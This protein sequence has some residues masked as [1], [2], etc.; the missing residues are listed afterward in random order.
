VIYLG[1][2]Q[3]YTG[4]AMVAFNAQTG[5]HHS[6]LKNF[7]R[8]ATGI[9][10]LLRIHTWVGGSLDMLTGNARRIRHVAM[11]GYAPGAKFGRETAGELGC[12]VKM[13]LLTGLD[14][15]IGYPTI[16]PPTSL[17]KFVLGKGVGGKNEMLLGVYKKWGAEFSDDNLADAYGLARL[18]HALDGGPLQHKYEQEVL[19]GLHVHTERSALPISSAG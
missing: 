14:D 12:I 19:G 9:D 8:G 2:D 11:E 7:S 16:V 3:S 18:A 15:P 13:A 1:I 10:R 6:A 5:E 17:K 4:F